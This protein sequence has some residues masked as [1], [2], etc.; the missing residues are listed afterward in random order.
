[1]LMEPQTKKLKKLVD[2]T[3]RKKVDDIQKF[4]AE[5]KHDLISCQQS[6][7]FYVRFPLSKVHRDD[8]A[9]ATL[10][11]IRNIPS[12]CG[13]ENCNLTI[14]KKCLSVCLCLCAC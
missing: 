5:P 13:L 8:D 4:R 6:S 11:L 10:A 1:M 3:T 7:K 2:E 9:K 14:D 12:M